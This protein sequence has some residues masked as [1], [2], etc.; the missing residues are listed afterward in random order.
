MFERL[1]DPARAVVIEAQDVAIEMGLAYLAAGHLLYGCAVTREETAGR[2]LHD[3]GITAE[4]IR[5]SLPRSEEQPG[6][7]LDP[8]ALRAIGI[9]YDGVR[10]AVEQTFGPGALEAAPDRRGHEA[11]MRKP[12]FAPESK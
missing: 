9:D 3:A 4:T 1:T 6:G 12:R 8:D 5:R 7:Q 2:P 11:N 10:A